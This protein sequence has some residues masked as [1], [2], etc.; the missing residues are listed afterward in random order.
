[1]P[2]SHALRPQ[3]ASAASEPS[4]PYAIPSISRSDPNFYDNTYCAPSDPAPPFSWPS[5]WGGRRHE[6][7]AVP[8]I[9]APP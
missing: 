6:A 5:L 2:S 7:P 8:I 1:M 4:C 3:F 9:D